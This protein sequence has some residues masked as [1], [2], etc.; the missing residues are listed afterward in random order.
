MKMWSRGRPSSSLLNHGPDSNDGRKS[1]SMDHLGRNSA[2]STGE[3]D[4]RSSGHGENYRSS[5][6]SGTSSSRQSRARGT[7]QI[8]TVT[9]NNQNS[10]LLRAETDIHVCFLHDNRIFVFKKIPSAGDENNFIVRNPNQVRDNVS[11]E[12]APEV[13]HMEDLVTNII[14]HMLTSPKYRLLNSMYVAFSLLD[15]AF[16]LTIIVLNILGF[17][18]G[19]YSVTGAL[20]RETAYKV[21]V[22][23]MIILELFYDLMHNTTKFW[24]FQRLS[25]YI[26]ICFYVMYYAA[27]GFLGPSAEYDIVLLQT[28]ITLRL[29]A[30]AL[31]TLV[32]VCIDMNIHNDLILLN[33]PI[34][35]DEENKRVTELSIER[36]VYD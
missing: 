29:I 31:E 36:Y 24:I 35:E 19:E 20:S 11:I 17:A 33:H 27:V 1:I 12:S 30:F 26:T 7:H 9:F 10:V 8:S 5:D 16:L 14:L 22:A 13:P 15:N 32:D 25:I 34:E 3:N 2:V 6:F 18:Q 28:L 4:V 23:V 21:P